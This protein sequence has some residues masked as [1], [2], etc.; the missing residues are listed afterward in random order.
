MVSYNLNVRCLI[1]YNMNI[2]DGHAMAH[3]WS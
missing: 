2:N 1:Q 3:K